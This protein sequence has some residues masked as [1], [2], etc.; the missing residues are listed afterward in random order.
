MLISVVL[1]TC[2]RSQLLRRAL[3]ALLDQQGL[4]PAVDYEV[5]LVDNN[6][7]DDTRDVVRACASAPGGQRLSYI[8][9]P[10]QGLAFGRNTGVL[11][12]RGSIIAFTDD[13]VVV[14]STWVETIREAFLD[15]PDADGVG[16]KTLPSWPSPPPRWLTPLHWVGPLALQDYGERRFVVDARCPRCL[17]GANLALRRHVF[18]RL[19]LFLPEFAFAEDTELLLRLW[20]SGGRCIYVPEMLVHAQIQPERL[21]KAYHRRWHTRIGRYNARMHYEELADP[22][23]GLRNSVPRLSRVF[24]LPAFALR[25]IASAAWQWLRHTAAGRE[26]EAFSHE[27]RIRSLIAYLG[28]TR[29]MLGARRLALVE[30]PRAETGGL[31]REPVVTSGAGS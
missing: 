25:Q 29:R 5:L 31:D 1:S 13:D 26:D 27:L 3:T 11:A 10:R 4:S 20:L 14:S 28:E 6:S 15:Y 22:V 9:E 17:A 30:A 7:T 16:G 19:G 12:A 24:G 18:D 8:F 23:R 2:N 21:T